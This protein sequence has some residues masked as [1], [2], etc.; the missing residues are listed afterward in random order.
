MIKLVIG[1]GIIIASF[2]YILINHDKSMMENMMDKQSKRLDQMEQE[3]AEKAAR[4]E[5]DN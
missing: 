3:E 2:I 4:Q 1:I 5:K